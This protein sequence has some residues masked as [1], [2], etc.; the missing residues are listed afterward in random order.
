MAIDNTSKTGIVRLEPLHMFSLGVFLAEGQ[1][2][3]G[4]WI[5]HVDPDLK[6]RLSA[7]APLNEPECRVR[8]V[9]APQFG[10]VRSLVDC[11]H[12]ALRFKTIIEAT[13]K[14]ALL[15]RQQPRGEGGM[16]NTV[17]F[18]VMFVLDSGVLHCNYDRYRSGWMIDQ[19]S[20]S[21]RHEFYDAAQLVSH[22]PS[23]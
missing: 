8:I 3:D 7:V 16:L 10:S 12:P 18:Q 13:A 11:I 21:S 17:G 9:Q 5:H 22:A 19:R 20:V 23:R 2:E 4:V 6:E 1:P 15:M 14:M